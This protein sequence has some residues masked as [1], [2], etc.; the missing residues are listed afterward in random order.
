MDNVVALIQTDDYPEITYVHVKE[1][2]D[3]GILSWSD[4]DVVSRLYIDELAR[5]NQLRKRETKADRREKC[6]LIS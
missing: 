4:V 6:C 5:R 3:E 2:V 1:A